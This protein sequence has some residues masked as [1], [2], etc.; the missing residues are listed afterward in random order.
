MHF[1]EIRT[2]VHSLHFNYKTL[3]DCTCD[4][5]SI[6]SALVTSCRLLFFVYWV[7]V[8]KDKKHSKR[9]EMSQS[10]IFT[11]CELIFLNKLITAQAYHTMLII[12]IA[13]IS[14]FR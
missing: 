3:E 2:G 8:F 6:K 10:V 11:V 4:S 7:V 1:C 14:R 5:I 9:N 13:T 12:A